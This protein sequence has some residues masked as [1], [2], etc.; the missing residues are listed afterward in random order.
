MWDWDILHFYGVYL[1]IAVFVLNVSSARLW[2]LAVTCLVLSS[3]FQMYLDL[4]TDASVWSLYGMMIEVFFDGLHPVFPWMTYL[5]VG[6]WIGRQDLSRQRLGLRMLVIALVVV[7]GCAVFDGIAVQV[8]DWLAL[9]GD[10]AEWFDRILL[11]PEVIVVCSDTGSAVAV[12]CLCIA[13]TQRRA[14]HRWVMALVATGQLAFTLYIVHA[15]AI[16]IP[17]QHGLFKGAS[18]IV[19]IGYSLAFYLVA[20]FLCVWWR[21]RWP[22]GPLEGIIRQITGRTSPAPWGGER[23]P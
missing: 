7:A 9:A 13:F 17:V 2:L 20:V 10:T 11:A 4:T 14:E 8:D 15:V 21:K 5:L 22:Y 6:M 16:L 3:V 18:L 12:L 23:L 1:A 19:S